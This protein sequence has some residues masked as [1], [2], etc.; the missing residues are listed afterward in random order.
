M[1]KT[2]FWEIVI[3]NA[4]FVVGVLILKELEEL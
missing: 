1:K 3:L 2:T 4:G